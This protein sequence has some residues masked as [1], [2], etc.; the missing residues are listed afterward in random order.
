MEEQSLFLTELPEGVLA[1]ILR[2][3]DPVSLSLAAQA[4]VAL[5][6]A[7]DAAWPPFGG[8]HYLLRAARA[9]LGAAT[10]LPCSALDVRLDY[11]QSARFPLSL[12]L[13]GL[14]HALAAPDVYDAAQAVASAVQ[15]GGHGR[16]RVPAVHAVPKT[17]LPHMV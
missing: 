12:P 3:L 8:Q 6:R 2:H 17:G 14:R 10:H 4:C 9:C 1:S 16:C 7:A 5:L 11:A 15:V 13:H